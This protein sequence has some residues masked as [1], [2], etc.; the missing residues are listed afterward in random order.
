VQNF[1]KGIEDLQKL[2]QTLDNDP[3]FQLPDPQ[4]LMSAKSYKSKFADPLV[5]KLKSLIKKV[6]A[7]CIQVLDDY[8]RLNR[9]NG[10]LY[11]ENER[12]S[13]TNDRLKGENEILRAENKD[14]K[15]LRKVFGSRQI[16]TLLERARTSKQ[17]EKRLKTNDER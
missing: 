6:L 4:P 7:R 5:K 13:M 12:L 2:E 8:H 1:D 11:R 10:Q 3:A 14:Y 9:Y 16:D 15:L 17:R